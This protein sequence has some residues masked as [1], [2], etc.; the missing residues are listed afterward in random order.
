[1]LPA[2]KMEGVHSQGTAVTSRSWKTQGNELFVRDS[3]K[4]SSPADI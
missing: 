3:K 2:L 1:M 4:E